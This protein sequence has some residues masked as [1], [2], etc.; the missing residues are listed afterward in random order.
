MRELSRYPSNQLARDSPP[1]PGSYAVFSGVDAYPLL[2]ICHP[3][4][5]VLPGLPSVPTE[6]WTT[7][8]FQS[9]YCI[10]PYCRSAE[11]CST[12]LSSWELYSP[13]TTHSSADQLRR[14]MW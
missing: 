2:S 10:T 4:V 7:A 6:P 11:L 5:R 9:V 12:V 3:S 14:N 1:F 8:L 13:P